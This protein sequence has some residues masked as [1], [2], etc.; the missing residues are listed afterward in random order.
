MRKLTAHALCCTRF[1]LCRMSRHNLIVKALKTFLLKCLPVND[2]EVRVEAILHDEEGLEL[3]P[4]D[5]AIR[6][7]HRLWTVDVAITSPTALAVV[8]RASKEECVAISVQLNKKKHK[9]KKKKICDWKI[10]D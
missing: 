9:R 1:A 2:S 3:P 4:I 10:L 5:L 6:E 8:D 7:N